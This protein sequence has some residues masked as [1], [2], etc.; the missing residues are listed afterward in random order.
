MVDSK[1]FSL[2]NVIK[3]VD[4]K[5]FFSLFRSHVFEL[6]L[7]FPPPGRI[8]VIRSFRSLVSPTQY[9]VKERS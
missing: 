3:I 1:S 8:F 9:M 5:L 2:L 6:L 7:K 4:E